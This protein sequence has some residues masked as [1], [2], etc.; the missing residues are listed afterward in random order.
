[1]N[2][3]SAPDVYRLSEYRKS[4]LNKAQ[5]GLK[6]ALPARQT[7]AVANLY[8][9]NSS[10]GDMCSLGL[11]CVNPVPAVLGGGE[12]KWVRSS[13]FH[14][15]DRKTTWD[16]GWPQFMVSRWSRDGGIIA[17]VAPVWGAGAGRNGCVT[18]PLPNHIP[19]GW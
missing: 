4:N 13:P 5:A 18:G 9:L 16:D 10:I 19:F 11:I 17:V 6:G 15:G 1:M 12:E 2:R 7:V 3:V 14:F 8:N